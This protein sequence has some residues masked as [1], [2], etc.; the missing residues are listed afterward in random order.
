MTKKKDPKDIKKS[1]RPT[2][3]SRE[4]AERIC[5]EIAT[6][7]DGV[8]KLCSRNQEFPAESTIFLWL[9]KH[10]EFS[11]QYEKAREF[12]CNVMA[13]KILEVAWDNSQDIVETE[14]G[15]KCN[16]EFISRS[17]LKVDSLK[18]LLTKL[19]AKKYG[20]KVQNDTTVTMVTQ[21]EAI[22]LLK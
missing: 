21:D 1:G 8:G 6:S 11:E 13:D 20:D 5:S 9:T 3:Y 4:V 17:R 14:Y 18:W 2:K 12:Q 10:P 16:S 15:S 22:K 7:I 19:N